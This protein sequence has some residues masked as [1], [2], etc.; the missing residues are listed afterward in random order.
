MRGAYIGYYTDYTAYQQYWVSV[1]YVF[2][3]IKIH[4]SHARSLDSQ[5]RGVKSISRG[6][7]R[8][9]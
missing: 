4:E 2:V 5:C 7:E 9:N 6:D 8:Q 1:C 3:I